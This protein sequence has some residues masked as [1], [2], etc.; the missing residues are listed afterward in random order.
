MA[1]SFFPEIAAL[2]PAL[3][4]TTPMAWKYLPSLGSQACTR[5]IALTAKQFQ[6]SEHQLR[7]TRTPSAS[8]SCLD[9]TQATL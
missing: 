8:H 7:I 4:A 6:S 5:A 2:Q 9:Q 3:R 1:A